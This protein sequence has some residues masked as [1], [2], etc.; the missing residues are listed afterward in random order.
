VEAAVSKKKVSPAEDPTSLGNLVVKA[1]VCTTAQLQK[2]LEEKADAED[3]LLGQILVRMGVLTEPL[4]QR[5]LEQ[6][7]FMRTSNGNGTRH[8][9]QFASLAANATQALS[10][11]LNDLNDLARQALRK[12]KP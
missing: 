8:A 4:L 6:Q 1:G 10:G 12:L 3:R 5:F 2:A 7:Q 9:R 11:S